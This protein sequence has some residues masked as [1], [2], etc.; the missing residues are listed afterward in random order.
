MRTAE[1]AASDAISVPGHSSRFPV[2]CELIWVIRSQG[3]GKVEL[4]SCVA[5]KGPQKPRKGTETPARAR[6]CPAAE[7][8][9]RRA[10]MSDGEA[11]ATSFSYSNTRV[12]HMAL[13]GPCF[14]VFPEHL[15][16][17]K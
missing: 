9:P 17:T 7:G 5:R 13:F 2:V 15:H 3:L 10:G 4:M 16:G 8:H 1:K 14:W 6:R 11:Y 12:A